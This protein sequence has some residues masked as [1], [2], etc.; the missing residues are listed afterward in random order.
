MVN[1]AVTCDECGQ[2]QLRIHIVAHS[3]PYSGRRLPDGWLGT[4]QP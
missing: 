3:R 2:P 4:V 1:C